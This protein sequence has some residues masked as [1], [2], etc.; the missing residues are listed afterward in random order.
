MITFNKYKRFLQIYLIEYFIY[1]SFLLFLLLKIN[2]NIPLIF[3]YFPFN[4]AINLM[5]KKEKELEK[6]NAQNPK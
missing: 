6:V 2:P 3:S 1:F 5:M 4:L